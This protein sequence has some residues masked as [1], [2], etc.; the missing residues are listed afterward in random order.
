MGFADMLRD[1]HRRHEELKYRIHNYR[2]PLSPAGQRFMGFVYFCIPVV[3][4]YYLMQWALEKSEENIGKNGA[5]LR[6]LRGGAAE[7]QERQRAEEA[8]AA[9]RFAARSNVN[10]R[11][12]L[13]ADSIVARR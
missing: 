10:D 11:G 3:G 1:L 13:D 6:Q 9:A 2:L 12:S 8:Q 4:G 7:E 5:K